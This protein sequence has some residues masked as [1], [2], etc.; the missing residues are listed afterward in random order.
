MQYA[1]TLK[2]D[3]SELVTAGHT[4]W[5]LYTHSSKESDVSL[6]PTLEIGNQSCPVIISLLYVI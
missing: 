6:T 2:N 5:A 4:A 1:E 3:E